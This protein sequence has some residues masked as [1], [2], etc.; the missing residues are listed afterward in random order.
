MECFVEEILGDEEYDVTQNRMYVRHASE[1]VSLECMK[2][3]VSEWIKIK[4]KKDGNK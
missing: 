4:F 2:Y 3:S 1:L